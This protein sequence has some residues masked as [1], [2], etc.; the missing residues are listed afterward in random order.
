MSSGACGNEAVATRL[1]GGCIDGVAAVWHRID[2]IAATT[3][4][5][6]SHEAAWHRIDVVVSTR[7]SSRSL[8]T[9][10]HS[11]AHEVVGV[12]DARIND[13]LAQRATL[14]LVVAARE[15]VGVD[16]CGIKVRAPHAIDA[17]FSLELS[18]LDGVEQPNSLLDFHTGVHNLQRSVEDDHFPTDG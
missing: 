18:L 9:L 7:P 6:G 17:M 11:Q 10:R 12:V 4:R 2:A 1:S 3:R 15:G 8:K 14:L 5:V 13:L 16:L